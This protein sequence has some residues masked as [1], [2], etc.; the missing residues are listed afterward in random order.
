MGLPAGW[1]T[2]P[3]ISISRAEQLKA[4]GNGV[5]PQ[6]AVAALQSMQAIE[7]PSAHI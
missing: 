4:I 3:A 1:V 6:Q 5:C 7:R 2:D